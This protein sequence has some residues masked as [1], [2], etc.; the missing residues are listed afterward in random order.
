MQIRSEHHGLRR[1]RKLEDILMATKGGKNRP[2]Q[3]IQ[4]VHFVNLEIG[5]DR[6]QGREMKL[7]NLPDHE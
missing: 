1:K 2:D 7:G 3:I 5:E 6:E 4:E